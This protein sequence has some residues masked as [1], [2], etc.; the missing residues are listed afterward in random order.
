VGEILPDVA[1]STII[2]FGTS[3]VFE[4]LD[5][6]TKARLLRLKEGQ[7][8][9]GE[10]FSKELRLNKRKLM[11]DIRRNAPDIGDD[12]AADPAK[13]QGTFPEMQKQAEAVQRQVWPELDEALQKASGAKKISAGS[14]VVPTIDIRQSLNFSGGQFAEMTPDDLF[15]RIDDVI[16]PKLKPTVAKHAVDDIAGK[17]RLIYNRNDWADE[18][19]QLINKAD[20]LTIPQIEDHAAKILTKSGIPLIKRA[21]LLSAMTKEFADDP[22]SLIEPRQLQGMKDLINQRPRYMT[23]W[24]ASNLKTNLY[25]QIPDNYWMLSTSGQPAN[26]TFGGDVK[27]SMARWLNKSIN[28][29]ADKA[30]PGLGTVV[31]GLN[32]RYGVASE[33]LAGT[34]KRQAEERTKSAFTD[35]VRGFTQLADKIMRKVTG[36][37]ATRTR[38]AQ[39]LQTLAKRDSFAR[40]VVENPVLMNMF[41]DF[42][43]RGSVKL[44][45]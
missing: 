43:G 4:G 16:T 18:M 33:V 23:L 14:P 5:A 15:Q 19:A 7:G 28:K 11:K 1:L 24:E 21:D 45:D 36:S 37:T 30:Q 3:A 32:K 40:I 44:K 31:K 13:Y 17:F 39:M 34:V 38:V 20:D 29:S 26:V 9:P 41:I 27:M 10:I 22:L 6:R 12:I 8:K 42:F 25:D 2:A 35:N